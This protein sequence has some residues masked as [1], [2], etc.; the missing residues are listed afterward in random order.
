MK[1]LVLNNCHRLSIISYF[2][3]LRSSCSASS[4]KLAH[5]C[6]TASLRDWRDIFVDYFFFCP[7]LISLNDSNLCF[8]CTAYHINTTLGRTRSTTLINGR[9]M[10]LVLSSTGVTKGVL[11]IIVA[12][13]KND[14]EL[15]VK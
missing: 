14:E 6:S 12:R 2:I 7:D 4:E 1:Q 8:I 11:Q 13:T 9:I 3:A 5:L 15:N 10:K